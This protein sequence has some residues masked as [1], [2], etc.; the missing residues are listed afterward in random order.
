MKSN[1]EEI[2]AVKKKLVIEIDADEVNRRINGAYREFGKRAKIRGFRPGKIPRQILEQY[3][4]N[5]VMEDVTRDLV[6]DTLPKALDQTNTLPLT[7]PVVE[8]DTLKA[9][10][11]FKY[12]AIMEVRPHFELGDYKGLDVEKEMVSVSEED[13]DS[14]LDEIR[15]A[16]G[17]LL[18]VGEE[19]GIRKD[20]HVVI[21]Y[22]GFEDDKPLEGIKSENFL[23]RIGS[24]DFHRDF[25]ESLIGIRRGET[26]EIKVDFE[27]NYGHARLAGKG[28]NFKVRVIDIKEMEVPELDDDFATSLGADFK[29]VNELRQK[30]KEELI[31]RE[32]KR[33]DDE[34][35]M[36]LLKKVS[37]G[38]DFELPP[39]LVESEINYAIESIR[40]NI[41]RAGSSLERAG[42]NVEKLKEDFRGPSEKRVKDML[43][44]GE[45]ARENNL[46]INDS[47]LSQGYGELAAKVGQEQEAVRR[48]YEVNNLV[49][50]LRQKLLEEK[51]LNYLVKDAKV[52]EVEPDKIQRE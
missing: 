1:L 36:R 6:K 26:A 8:N 15:K 22:E 28:V 2:S 10:Q 44:L 51:T 52:T 31:A 37:H 30:V 4:E 50:S 16:H 38:V 19:R 14:Q 39:S 41:T 24:N 20:D 45:V 27:E 34:L 33:T 42:L 25:E 7:M 29:D 48:Y 13:V 32:E 18:S 43:V 17:K 47:E 21:E 40:Q 5:Q 12:S 35:K 9:G 3:F 11:A 23:L 49:D 46:S